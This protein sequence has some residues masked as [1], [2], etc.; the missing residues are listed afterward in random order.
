MQSTLRRSLRLNRLALLSPVLLLIML[1][2]PK[3]AKAQA[4]AL[5]FIPVTPCRLVDT[6]FGTGDFAGPELA[7]ATTRTF[8][9]PQGA[10][11]IPSTAAAYS[12]N[13]TA[14]PDPVLAWMTIWPAGQT[15]PM[16]ST[17]NSTGRIKANAV[18]VAAGTNGG[19]SVW[20]HD[21]THLILDVNGYFV[22]A[23]TDSSA[24]Q[25]FPVAPCRV[26]DTRS[27]SGGG[28]LTARETAS[29][30]IQGS[31]GIPSTAKAYSLNF[32]AVPKN[33]LDYLTTWAAGQTQPVVSTLNASSG[34][35]TI[36][37]NA[38]IVGAGTSGNI[39]V[40][41][42]DA[43]DLI[44]DVNGYFAPPATGGLSYY[45]VTECRVIDTRSTAG[46]FVG[47]TA[48]PVQDS[49]CAPPATA[50]AYVVNATVLPSGSLPYLSLWAD[51]TSQPNTSTLNSYDAQ[52]TSNMAIVGNTMGTMDAFAF[53]SNA[54]DMLID[55]SG[56]FAP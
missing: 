52:I 40:F 12:I 23:G 31:C 49:T 50:Q 13:V 48:V 21:P 46:K 24:L 16:V 20:A 38:A 9:V 18:I 56:Y 53:G 47:T 14:L 55:L 35:G 27:G 15:M 4:T 22:P 2:S 29:F 54:T 17:L 36:T 51:G 32:T 26:A 34:V 10:C 44:I 7:A 5:Q 6:R 19:I 37:A 1:T 28:T 43:I 42:T 8:N 30:P 45:P 11:G 41:V 33:S 25:F 39:S 3:V